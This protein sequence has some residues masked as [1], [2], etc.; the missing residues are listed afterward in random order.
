MSTL[1]ELSDL[2]VTY[3]IPGRKTKPL[4]A[5]DGVSL[6]VNAGETVGLVG[7]SGSGKSTIGRAVLGLTPAS[8][9]EIRFDGAD[10]THA[11]GRT[12]R[13]LA[14]DL[15]VIFQNPF[16]SLN[17]SHPVGKTLAEPLLTQPGMTKVQAE[18]KV[19]EL[20]RAVGL[21]A[22]AAERYP[23]KFSGGQRQRIAIARALA[24]SPKLVVCDEAVSALDVSTQAQVINLLDELQNKLGVAYLFIAHDIAVVRHI[25]DR[26][27]VLYRGQVMESGPAER[28]CDRPLHPY[29]KALVAA[30]PVANP[31]L[32]RQRRELRRKS[33]SATTAG[34][35]HASETG[36]PF[37]VRCPHSAPVCLSTRPARTVCE[38]V[39]VACH[40]YDSASTHP[41]C[42]G[43]QRVPVKIA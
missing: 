14:E 11:S 4:R 41:E 19:T 27:V 31:V 26:V 15:Q 33:V 2:E 20:L 32:Q 9:G 7:E 8:G 37:A 12:R 30:A 43:A 22:D 17:P 18:A 38:G 6:T 10:I 36:C 42:V 28:V 34:A 13:S 1:L 5:V 35:S 21:P 16:S 29:T 23:D 25:S 3:R 40:L 39:E 24:I